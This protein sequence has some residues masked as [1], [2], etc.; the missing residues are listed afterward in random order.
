MIPANLETSR[1]TIDTGIDLSDAGSRAVP[2]G[3][4]SFKLTVTAVGMTAV[5]KTFTDESIAIEVEAGTARTFTLQALD[6]SGNVIFSGSTTI[7]LAAGEDCFD[8][9]K[10]EHRR[11]LHHI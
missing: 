7:N 8:C 5:E 6:V 11:I 3:I 2:T 9:Y 10:Y 1:V 4:A